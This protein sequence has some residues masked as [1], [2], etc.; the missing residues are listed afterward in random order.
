MTALDAVPPSEMVQNESVHGYVR[1]RSGAS[2]E[3]V[4][5]RLRTFADHHVAGV[6]NGFQN[7]KAYTFVL[8]PLPAAH[9]L[10]PSIGDM[11]PPAD[12]GLVRTLAGIAILIL[13]VAGGN[14]VSMMT[15]RAAR[16]AVE[17]GVRKSV[18][19]MRR[20]VM[21]QFYGAGF[22]DQADRSTRMHCI[23]GQHFRLGAAKEQNG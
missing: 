6:I 21:V 15:A 9:F 20:Q 7:S 1:L 2:I 8:T 23:P 22:C 14:F 10:P 3:S 11:K 16:R 19:A 5:A 4:R 17:V 13:C 18:G 12:R